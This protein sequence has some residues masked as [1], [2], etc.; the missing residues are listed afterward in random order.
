MATEFERPR[1]GWLITELMALVD[2]EGGGRQLRRNAFATKKGYCCT[3]KIDTK[4]VVSHLVEVRHHQARHRLDVH[5]VALTSPTRMK[6]RNP[7]GVERFTGDK[8]ACT[9][10]KT[11]RS[12]KSRS[13]L[14]IA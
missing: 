5:E 12:S 2:M 9:T 8:R 14:T 3:F 1:Y 4:Y 10:S 11:A 7:T 13:K 6:A